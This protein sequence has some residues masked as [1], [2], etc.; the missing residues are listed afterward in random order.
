MAGEKRDFYEVLG[1]QK[2]ASEDE[3]KKA[4]R[5]KAKEFH[6]DLHPG[7]KQAEASFKEVNEAYEVLSDADKKAR[8]DQF[9]HAGV[10][11]NFGAG[12]AGG[13]GGGWG[14]TDFDFGDIFSSFF[15]GGG[16]RR[17]NP[18]APRRG[19]D[20]SASVIISFEE[21]A[22]GCRKQVE[23]VRVIETCRTC[24][25]TGAAKGTS[26]TT[27]PNCHGTGQEVRQQRTPFGV[28][29]TQSVCSRCQGK[30]KIVETPCPDCRGGGQVRVTTT[31]GV[32]IPAG[33]DD[34]QILTVR[35]KGNSGVN[36]GPAGDLNVEV[37]VRP[38]PIFEREGY[39]L[40]CEL[41]LTYAQLALGAEIEIPTLEGKV[42]YT[43]KEGTQPNEL[44]RLR[45]KGIPYVNGRGK[46]DLIARITVEIPKN[47][48]A[49]QKQALREFEE[50]LG[51]KNYQ[52]RKNFFDKVKDAFN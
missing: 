28:M 35:G 34:G 49:K 15:G 27:C 13:Y 42:P 40:L 18:N 38:H 43:I 41:P 44:I 1:I 10:D 20:A 37:S 50:A 46:G 52:K 12:G 3:I 26:P 19:S 31:V 48:S 33:I 7:D 22:R 47:L 6:P 8:Y 29:Q 5:K 2:G 39:N 36:G 17:S 14:A 51:D 25:G 11:P 23:N 4:Y 21:A 16:G 45:G 9:G 32:N 24:G 30:G